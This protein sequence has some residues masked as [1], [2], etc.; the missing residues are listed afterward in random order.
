VDK[1]RQEQVIKLL[2][3]KG[4]IE[5]CPR[6]KHPQF[7]LIGESI[8]PVGEEQKT[9]LT[10]TSTLQIPVVVLACKQCGYIIFHATRVLEPRPP[11]M[12]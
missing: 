3:E 1:A 4:A 11:F 12:V 10:G 7:E 8:F 6:C 9:L 5:P 2:T